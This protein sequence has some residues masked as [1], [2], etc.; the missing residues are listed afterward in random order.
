[1]QHTASQE[2]FKS[3]GLQ[4]ALTR[5]DASARRLR[6]KAMMEDQGIDDFKGDIHPTLIEHRN[7]S[8]Q[9]CINIPAEL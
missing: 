4:N 9:P 2:I 3:D 6:A 1:M 8:K 5:G 7:R